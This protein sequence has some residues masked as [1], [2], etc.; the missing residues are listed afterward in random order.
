[1]Y[2]RQEPGWGFYAIFHNNDFGTVTDGDG[3]TYPNGSYCEALFEC[4]PGESNHREALFG[5]PTCGGNGN[6]G[7]IYHDLVEQFPMKD[8]KPIGTSSEYPYDPLNPAEGRDPRFA[9]TVVWNGSVMMSGGDKDHVVYTHKGVGATTDAFGSGT[10]TGYYLSLIHIF[11]SQ[12]TDWMNSENDSIKIQT[13]L[14]EFSQCESSFVNSLSGE[15]FDAIIFRIHPIC[16]LRPDN[17][18][19]RSTF[20]C[21]ESD[22]PR[23]ISVSYTHLA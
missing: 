20:T 16:Q 17:R 2:K 9:N 7:Y 18:C 12:L 22:F 11:W 8:G 5:P 3:V 1:M 10:P 14:R 6:G 4:R 23:S 19:F 21:F 13:L 15:V